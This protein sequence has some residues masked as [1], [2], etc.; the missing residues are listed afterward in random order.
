MGVSTAILWS[1]NFRS[2]RHILELRTADAAEEE[3]R[4]VF[5][6]VGHLMKAEYP[7]HFQDFEPNDLGEWRTLNSKV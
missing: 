6:K 5:N 1:C 3:I 4:F 2:L 7:N